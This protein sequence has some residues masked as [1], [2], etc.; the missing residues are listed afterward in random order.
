MAGLPGVGVRIEFFQQNGAAFVEHPQPAVQHV[1]DDLD[2]ATACAA[3]RLP[4]LPIALD[5]VVV[6]DFAPVLHDEAAVE[7]GLVF[8]EAQRT[9]LPPPLGRG[10]P[11]QRL[12]GRDVVAVLQVVPQAQGESA[13]RRIHVGGPVQA[14]QHLFIGT[15][16]EALDGAVALW[17]SGLAVDQP[18]LQPALHDGEH[19]GRGEAAAFV[20]IEQIGQPVAADDV[21]KP[22]QQQGSRL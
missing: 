13:A 3:G 2:P 12:V 20:Q 17:V 11:S 5:D 6:R 19:I 10:A 15:A 21:A 8:G 7:V 14:A 16:V 1:P 9:A 4:Q 22:V 18:G